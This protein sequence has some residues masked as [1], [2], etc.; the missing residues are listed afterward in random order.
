MPQAVARIEEMIV[1]GESHQI[2]TADL[3]FACSTLKDQ[4]LKRIGCECSMVLPEKALVWLSRL[5]GTPLNAGVSAVELIPELGRMSAE[6]GYGIYLLGATEE[7]LRRVRA[8]LEAICPGVKIVGS[9]SPER[10]PVHEMDNEDLLARIEAAKPEI[11]LV[12]L[13]SPKQEVWIHRH[14]QGLKV[15]VAIGVGDALEEF[16][17]EGKAPRFRMSVRAMK[18]VAGM[19]AH[20]PLGMLAS[21]LQPDERRQ[22]K[23]KVEVEGTVRVVATPPK[24]SGEICRSLV[25]EARAASAA[26][27]TL[28]VDMSA[29]IRIEADG[30]GGLLEIRRILLSEGLW[31]WLAGMSNPVRRVLQFADMSDLFRI[32]ASTAEAIRFTTVAGALGSRA[33]GARQ[34]VS[35][36]HVAR[37]S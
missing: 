17:G 13:G 35:G 14:R 9:C 24:V 6:R 30:L 23:L 22:G 5:L 12:A 27:Q 36:A 16:A 33:S 1:S 3:G 32:A 15:P 19:L 8:V 4:Y 11:L 25:L 26:G 28:V 7:T 20:L 34:K 31:I 37:A 21:H 18:D 10:Q 29:T 2:A